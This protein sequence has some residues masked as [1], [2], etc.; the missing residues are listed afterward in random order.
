M[1]LDITAYSLMLVGGLGLAYWASLPVSDSDP[2][3]VSLF[4][5]EPKAIA[6]MTLTG[7]EAEVAATRND[8]GR[9]WIDFKKAAPVKP[10]GVPEGHPAP[11]PEAAERF[12]A[13][14][15]MKDLLA[16]FNPLE[17][18]RS[19]G[20]VDQAALEEFG[21][22]DAKE[23]F[24]LTTASGSTFSLVL[25]KQSYG[26]RNRFVLDER[27]G[28][29]LLVGGDAFGD[30]ARANIRL[31][32]R[33]ILSGPIEE[34]QKAE[35]K[36]GGKERRFDH[37]KKDQNGALQWSEDSE[38]AAAN[39]GFKSWFDKIDRL[40]LVSYADAGQTESA[41]KQTPFLVV[42]F[43]KDNKPVDELRFVRVDEAGQ[44]AY[45]VKS[46]YLASWVKLAANRMEPIEKDIATML[47]SGS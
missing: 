3:K 45:W 39:A 14:E 19:L 38:G 24:T 10:E 23:K 41:E 18:Q 46:S 9:Y 4:S 29:V 1:R 37:T 13:G 11:A 12:L 32:E 7:G 15:K 5:V 44:A 47:G 6:K 27:D 30:L 25:G 28:K 8:E 42:N 31:F 34:V 17:A 16:A 43:L 35:I 22:K 26:S 20:K 36:A 40:R 2:N 21:L 33:S